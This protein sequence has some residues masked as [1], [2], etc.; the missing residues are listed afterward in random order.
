MAHFFLAGCGER[1]REA[2]YEGDLSEPCIPDR[3]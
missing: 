2:K 1:F 3:Q